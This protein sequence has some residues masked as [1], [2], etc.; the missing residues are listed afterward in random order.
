MNLPKFDITIIGAGVVGLSIARALSKQK[1]YSILIIEKNESFG[2]ETSSR[3]SEV[4]HSGIFNNIN[5]SKYKFCKEGNKLL[6]DFCEQ[7]KIWYNRCG[8]LI[9]S[10]K[11]EEIKFENFIKSLKEKKVQ[12]D[13]LTEE[14][15]S[16]IEPSVISEK[17]ILINNS[18]LVD[19]HGVMNHLF[20]ISSN[21]H[22]YLFNSDPKKIIKRENGYVME[23]RRKNGEVEEL[24][25]KIVINSAGLNSYNIASNIMGNSL[26]IPKMKFFKGSY[27][28]LST[29]WKDKFSKLVY[30][31]PSTDDAL[32]IH[33]SFDSTGRV[34]LGPDYEPVNNKQFDYSVEMKSRK[35]FFNSAQDYIK[36]L[37]MEDLNPD[38]SG[39]RPKLFYT[40]KES[41]EFYIKEESKNGYKNLINLIG[42]DSP[43]LTSSLRIGEYV[44]SIVSRMNP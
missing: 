6:Y 8:K 39:I 11:N 10:K 32:G 21:S 34:K 40:S 1:K 30:S 33:I 17:S 44:E 5:S 42:I 9:I 26:D 7:N 27:F 22:T 20:R 37:N 36:D 13:V 35:K 24:Y 3:N 16:A 12:F 28:S 2:E 23:I 4:I 15:T 18:G 14:E 43:G 38:Y 25:S 31:L 41:S 29:K 19:S